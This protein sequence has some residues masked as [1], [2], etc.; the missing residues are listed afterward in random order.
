MESTIKPIIY[1][2]MKS[3]KTKE[4]RTDNFMKLARSKGKN[5][6]FYLHALVCADL[7]WASDYENGVDCQASKM[8]N[9]LYDIQKVCIRL[10]EILG[11][12]K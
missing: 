3:A 9:Q 11:Y 2:D 12:K 4:E 10:D 8:F 6:A 1:E 5:E 7:F